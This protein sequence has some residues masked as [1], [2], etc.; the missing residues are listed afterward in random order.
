MNPGEA[1]T[2]RPSKS[3]AEQ[4]EREN[5]IP[6]SVS[7][8]SAVRTFLI[9]GLGIHFCSWAL[10]HFHRNDYGNETLGPVK[11][12]IECRHGLTVRIRIDAAQTLYDRATKEDR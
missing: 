10:C 1:V 7:T 11:P 9:P 8:W 4:M 2:D 12:V 5:R 3:D 6:R